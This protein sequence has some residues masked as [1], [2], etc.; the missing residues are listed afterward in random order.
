[1]INFED[2]HLSPWFFIILIVVALVAAAILSITHR[3]GEE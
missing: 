2:I 1:M 3:G